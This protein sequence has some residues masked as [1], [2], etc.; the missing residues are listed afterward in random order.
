MLQKIDYNY[1]VNEILNISKK[2]KI[3]FD[4]IKDFIKYVN[5]TI[6][7]EINTSLNCFIEIKILKCMIDQFSMQY[8]FYLK[9]L[10]IK[11][12][13]L[14]YNYTSNNLKNKIKEYDMLN[15]KS[16]E[17]IQMK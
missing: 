17:I 3:Y 13:I 8:E 14:I 7:D 9:E 4:Y 2:D 11:S 10:T 6:N 16:D 1:F 12:I 15:N 5:K